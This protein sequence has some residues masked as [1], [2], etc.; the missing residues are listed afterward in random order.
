MY[1]QLFQYFTSN[2]L[3]HANQ[4]GFRAEYSTELALSE[5]V[6]RIY[7]DLDEKQLP[8]AIFI[9][10]SK[11]FDTIDHTI[12]I[13]KLEHYGVENN[14]LQWFISYMHN[15]QQYVEIENIKSTTETIT[16][17]VP[18][19]SILGPLL[20]LIYI[21]DLALASTKF[22]PIMYADDT[23]LL[24]TLHNF[25]SNHSSNSLSYNINAELTKITQW[26]AVNRLSLNAKKT[27]M[28]IFHSK[29]NKLSVNEIPIIKINGMPIER[30]T[31]FKFLGVLIDSNLT[32]SPHCNYIAKKLSRICGVVSRLKHYVPT[33]ILTIIYNSLFL[34]HI[35]YGITSWGFNMCTRISKLQKK[36]I[37]F[38]TN[39]KF[40]SH[41]APL[42]KQFGLLK[43][44]DIFKLACFKLLYKY[45]NSKLPSYFNG[46]FVLQ[47]DNVVIRPRRIHRTPQR[48]NSTEEILQY[49]NVCNFKIKHTNSKFCRLCIRYKIPELI[50][51]NYLPKIVLEKM[52][53]HSYAGFTKYAKTYTI[54]KYKTTCKIRNCYVCK[55]THQYNCVSN[56]LNLLNLMLH[57]FTLTGSQW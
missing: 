25:K 43:A 20:F 9:D 2:N 21:I 31:E 45:E 28:M 51:D 35:S 42:F 11:A 49:N 24:S 27:K 29:Q 6:D 39:S 36:V 3:F 41:T 32:W 54:S 53:T 23:T 17:G 48:F 40:N 12:L 55:K 57:L 44:A 52:D 30:V 5:L 16:T 50:K 33:H 13:S 56:F 7:T 1:I 4:Y 14:E 15:R 10:L 19:G 34:T 18:Q 26:L 47:H 38:L 46:M 37:R 22:S 8:I